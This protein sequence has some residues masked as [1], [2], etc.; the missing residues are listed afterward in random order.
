MHKYTDEMINHLKSLESMSYEQTVEFSEKYLVPVKS[1]IAKL[2]ALQ[3]PYIPKVIERKTPE[4]PSKNRIV[5]KIQEKTG[6]QLLSLNKMTLTDLQALSDFI[7][8]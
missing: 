1:I 4:R 3:I 8:D 5:A 7:G 2:R 6:L